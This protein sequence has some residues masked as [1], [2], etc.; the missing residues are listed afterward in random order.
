MLKHASY[1]NLCDMLKSANKRKTNKFK[2]GNNTYCYGYPRYDAD[3]STGVNMSNPDVVT[4]YEFEIRYYG[5]RIAVVGSQSVTVT[6]GGYNTVSTLDRIN[7]ILG[8]SSISAR[9]GYRQD[10]PYMNVWRTGPNNF[11]STDAV[12][13]DS[14]CTFIRTESN[15]A[16]RE[17]FPH[18]ANRFYWLLIDASL[19]AH[20][21]S[22]YFSIK[23]GR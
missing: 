2:L 11:K 17:E 6:T 15:E 3:E 13:F 21:R 14:S 20:V 23:V 18:P 5:T 4:G 10:A 16:E 12:S 9:V 22:Q 19:P 7:D 1:T 8:S